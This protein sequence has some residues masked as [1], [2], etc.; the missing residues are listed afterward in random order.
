MKH[1]GVAKSFDSTAAFLQDLLM[2]FVDPNQK[3]AHDVGISSVGITIG[4]MLLADRPDSKAG[5]DDEVREPN[6]TCGTVWVS[7]D[8]P[9]FAWWVSSAR[10]S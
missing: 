3:T 8:Q 6:P 7:G 9:S 1:C 4:R 10:A 5:A 2:D